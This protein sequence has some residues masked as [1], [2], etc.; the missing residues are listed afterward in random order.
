LGQQNL[1]AQLVSKAIWSE[2]FNSIRAFE[3]HLALNGT[4]VV[5]FPFARLSA[6]A[7]ATSPGAARRTGEA[8]EILRGQRDGDK[9][10]GRY[11]EALRGVRSPILR[12]RRRWFALL[13]VADVMK[14]LDLRF[15]M[16]T[17]KAPGEL[18]RVRSTVAARLPKG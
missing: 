16:V 13:M 1:R 12:L 7:A 11:M 14:R 6:G 5:N 17:G 18:E 3:R 8:P 10:S 9:L 4:L 15:P 2:R